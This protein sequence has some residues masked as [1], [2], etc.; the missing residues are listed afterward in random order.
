MEAAWTKSDG[1]LSEVYRVLLSHP[2]QL[3][4]PL[5]KAKRPFEFVVSGLRALDVA[6]SPLMA[7]M[8][9][10]DSAEEMGGNSMSM[11]DPPEAT[12]KDVKRRRR[13]RN[14]TVTTLNRMGQPIW[15]PPS[16]AGFGDRAEEWINASQL[17]ER[18]AWCRNAVQLFGAD[19]DPRAFV[20]AVLADAAGDNTRKVV[21]QAPSRPY[22]LTL[23]LAS[24][25]F[26]RR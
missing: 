11:A 23:V 7:G 16:P 17:T 19:R 26:N 24:P 25:E 10:G 13:L 4:A 5:T 2:D 8:T 3:N 9:D 20:D 1:D 21:S 18:I 14:L 6:S 12:D 15:N 22:G